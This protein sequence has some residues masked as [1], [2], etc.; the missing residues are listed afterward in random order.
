MGRGGCSRAQKVV[1]I[2][3][4]ER[5]RRSSEF[6]PMTPLG[7]GAAE[8]ATRWRSTEATGGALM[9]R[10]FR[11]QGEEIGAGVGAVDNGGALIASFIGL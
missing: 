11:A 1:V 3:K 9:G 2:A 8:M 7:G 10:W 6:S 5:E 4:R